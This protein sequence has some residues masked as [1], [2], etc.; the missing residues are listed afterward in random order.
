MAGRMHPGVPVRQFGGGVHQPINITVPYTAQAPA[1]A[2]P[3]PM[4]PPPAAEMG[5]DIGALTIPQDKTDLAVGYAGRALPFVGMAAFAPVLAPVAAAFG[6]ASLAEQ[7]IRE[8]HAAK[9]PSQLPREWG[10]WTDEMQNAWAGQQPGFEGVN[11]A[12]QGTPPTDVQKFEYINAQLKS[13]G[14]DPI[15][16]DEYYQK[17]A[18]KPTTAPSGVR[19]Y[20]YDR[21]L[22]GGYTDWQAQTD[23]Q[24]TRSTEQAKVDIAMDDYARD[25][26]SNQLPTLERT[27]EDTAKLLQQFKQGD[28]SNA[29]VLAVSYTHLTLPTITE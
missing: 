9:N 18:Y 3:M 21:R 7:Y 10:S 23:E 29:G 13:E 1:K 16:I 17:Y 22:G 14:K 6:A 8:R 26:V 11:V 27:Y 5:Y 20:E 12:A 24:R 2:E 19:E 28:F 4:A 15:T 25:V